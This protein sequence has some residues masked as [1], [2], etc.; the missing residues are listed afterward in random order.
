VLLCRDTTIVLYRDTPTV[1]VQGYSK[2]C[3]VGILQVL[4]C[5]DSPGGVV[6]LFFNKCCCRNNPVAGR[7]PE[8]GLPLHHPHRVLSQ[9][10]RGHTNGFKGHPE[11]NFL[12]GLIRCISSMYVGVALG[13]C[14][15]RFLSN[16]DS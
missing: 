7:Y 12:P 1:T 14:G 8:T 3:C 16:A 15:I 2:C 11:G 4:L 5:R 13:Y 10:H 9:V 6:S